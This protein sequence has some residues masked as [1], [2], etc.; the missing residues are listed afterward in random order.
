MVAGR[1]SAGDADMFVCEVEV[2]QKDFDLGKH[3]DISEALAE[4]AGY[5]GPFVCFDEIEHSN[6]A[7]IVSEL[8]C[9]IPVELADDC[10]KESLSLKI[11]SQSINVSAKG[12]STAGVLDDK[13][14]LINI[15]AQSGLGFV[16]FQDINE[17]SATQWGGF[18]EAKNERRR[19]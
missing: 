2:S 11:N 1:N 13:G 4:E 7:R 9:S 19:E 16:A 17:E 3:Y 15:N 18:S 5:E 6:I 10:H 14:E 12:Y 8:N